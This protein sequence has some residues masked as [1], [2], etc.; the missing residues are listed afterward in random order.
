MKKFI[1]FLLILTIF[2]TACASTQTPPGESNQPPAAE[3][4]DVPPP[5][6]E[7]D[8]SSS[9]DAPPSAPSTLLPLPMTIQLENLDD[10]TI[11]VALS[12]GSI[13]QDHDGTLQILAAVY[14][15]DLYDAV[16]LSQLKTGDTIVIRSMKIA[17]TSLEYSSYG[18]LLINGGLDGGGYE[19][20][21]DENTVFYETGYSDV[22]AWQKVGVVTLTV[23]PDFVYTDSSDPDG[24]IVLRHYDDLLTSDNGIDYYFTPQNT[25]LVIENGMVTAMNRVYTP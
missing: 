24:E 14:A 4:P 21:T 5:T 9:T 8:T 25:T 2:L 15:Y 7:G 18:N 11:A 3:S 12:E 17:I 13:F 16:A 20:C 10:C 22:K 6:G 1:V 23:S 19:L